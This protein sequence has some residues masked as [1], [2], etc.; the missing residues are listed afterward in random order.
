MFENPEM[1]FA[2]GLLVSITNRDIDKLVA[3]KLGRVNIKPWEEKY[4][5]L[6][7]TDLLERR[8]AAE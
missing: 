8:G 2:T 4:M 7:S 6:F 1:K 3:K 5:N